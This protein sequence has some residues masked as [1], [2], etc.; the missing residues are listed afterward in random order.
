MHQILCR[1]PSER[2]WNA[3]HE[4]FFM[5]SYRYC[6]AGDLKDH[7]NVGFRLVLAGGRPK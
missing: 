3:H 1:R 5:S 4:Q 7:H 2:G 6:F